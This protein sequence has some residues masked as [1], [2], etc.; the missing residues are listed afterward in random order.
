MTP[1]TMFAKNNVLEAY[2]NKDP[3]WDPYNGSPQY[4]LLNKVTVPDTAA[5]R[6]YQIE[7]IEDFEKAALEGRFS[8]LDDIAKTNFNTAIS[9]FENDETKVVNEMLETFVTKMNSFYYVNK[10]EEKSAKDWE[11]L[12]RNLRALE[13]ALQ[14][15]MTELNVSKVNSFGMPTVL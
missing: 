6:A 15:L 2:A 9:A 13:T 4:S 1:G 10:D 11:Y 7:K 14:N 3:F 12:R 8:K 5:I